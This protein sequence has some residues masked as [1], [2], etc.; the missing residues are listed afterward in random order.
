MIKMSSSLVFVVDSYKVTIK[1][2]DGSFDY[3]NLGQ[4][5]TSL[6]QLFRD[7]CAIFFFFSKKQ[8]H[9]FL[10]VNCQTVRLTCVLPAN[11]VNCLTVLG[12]C[13]DGIQKEQNKDP[14]F[15]KIRTV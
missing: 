2:R 8:L 5:D 14:S 4:K 13:L 6:N 3:S 9:F 1:E 12:F 11:F 15:L 10:S 7:P